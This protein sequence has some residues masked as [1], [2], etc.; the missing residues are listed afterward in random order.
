[1]NIPIHVLIRPEVVIL[2]LTKQ[3]FESMLHDNFK[4][5]IDF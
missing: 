4:V 3:E 5:C 1:M 2:P